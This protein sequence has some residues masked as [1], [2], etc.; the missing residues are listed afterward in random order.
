[1]KSS[2]FFE[3]VAR[4]RLAAAGVLAVLVAGGAFGATWL[5]VDAD[6]LCALPASP[7]GLPVLRELDGR[8]GVLRTTLVAVSAPE[9]FSAEALQSLRAITTEAAKLPGVAHAQ[10]I[11]EVLDVEANAEGS[12][13]APLIKNIPADTA[14]LA[15][16]RT[17]VLT[18]DGV[19]GNLVSTKGDAALVVVS[20][21]PEVDARAVA[22][23]VR[24]VALRHRGPLEVHLS[25]APAVAETIVRLAGQRAVVFAPL[26]IVLCL[27]VWVVFAP[28]GRRL[29]ALWL[30]L[31]SAGVALV[32][33]TAAAAL[34]LSPLCNAAGLALLLPVA[35]GGAAGGLVALRGVAA[36]GGTMTVAALLTTAALAVF[37]WSP[38]ARTTA[39]LGAAG[40]LRAWLAALL[41]GATAGV[42]RALPV[43][44]G[45]LPAPAPA[46]GGG[47]A[48]LLG[49]SLL[50]VALVGAGAYGL[51]RL[52]PP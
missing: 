18:R 50:L 35:F 5:D 24:D 43:D 34:F 16:L 25:G 42:D 2:R 22:A 4:A 40:A 11:T 26:T 27:L 20:I 49:A 38:E 23:A 31:A 41:L 28:R 15:K 51:L 30:P 3:R 48:A 13:I 12:T 19:A 45:S 44:R 52:S 9:L 10:S 46:G 6:L 21:A 14:A 32:L 17:K 8:F 33:T 1:M 39:L 37:A 47:R 7:P 36:A 29:V